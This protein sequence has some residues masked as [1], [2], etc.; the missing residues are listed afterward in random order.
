MK[1][2]GCFDSNGKVKLS[3][4]LPYYGKILFFAV[5]Y[6][7]AIYVLFAKGLGLKMPAGILKG[8][9]PF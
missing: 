3:S 1:T 4:M 7:V 6:T 5:I 2:E 9:L 8:V